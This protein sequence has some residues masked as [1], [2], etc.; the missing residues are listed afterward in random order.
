MITKT[1]LRI[2]E[3]IYSNIDSTYGFN[4][5]AALSGHY[6]ESIKYFE[7]LVHDIV[8]LVVLNKLKLLKKVKSYDTDYIKIQKSID[9]IVG[10]LLEQRFDIDGHPNY[11][12]FNH[13]LLVFTV[14]LQI[15][16]HYGI[17]CV[18]KK[19]WN[20]AIKKTFKND[21]A[22][23]QISPHKH[24]LFINKFFENEIQEYK[25]RTIEFLDKFKIS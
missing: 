23:K 5:D 18:S 10:L 12:L 14:T 6:H 1:S 21:I 11:D 13:E 22:L 2:I 20:T 9:N 16:N 15:L 3:G 8:H 4:G 19:H 24:L 7:V 17:T 25:T